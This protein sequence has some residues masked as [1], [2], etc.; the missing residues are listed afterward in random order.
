MV[1][2]TVKLK[3]RNS[4]ISPSVRGRDVAKELTA[5]KIHDRFLRDPENRDSQLKIGWTEQK[6]IEMDK[7]AQD[8]HSYLLSKEEFQRYQKTLVSH[9]KQ[10]GQECT[11]TT[12]IRLPSRSH[13]HDRLHRESG[14]ERAEPFFLFNSVKDGAL[15][16]QVFLGGIGTRPKAGGAHEFN[17]FFCYRS[18]RLQLMAICCYLRLWD[19]DKERV[20]AIFRKCCVVFSME[21]LLSQDNRAGFDVAM[22]LKMSTQ[23]AEC[24]FDLARMGSWQEVRHTCI[25]VGC[26][27]RLT[28]FKRQ[29]MNA[30]VYSEKHKMLSSRRGMATS[31]YS[32]IFGEA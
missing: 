8:D 19:R 32:F 10:I 13:N 9:I 4:T 25:V 2:G 6:C 27:A 12:S 22:N 15:L 26:S 23:T 5:R 17:S 31:R 21:A 29:A 24:E 7:L 14:E 1:L 3:H 28:D 20:V 16:P 30:A 18:F 11:D